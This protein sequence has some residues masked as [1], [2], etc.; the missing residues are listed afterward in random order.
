MSISSNVTRTGTASDVWIFEVSGDLS[1]A[2]GGSVPAGIKVILAGG[3][4]ASNVYWVVTGPVNGVT[5][6]TYSTFNGTILS[7]TQIVMQ[8]GAVLNGRALAQ[9]QL[10]MDHNV[11]TLPS[12]LATLHVIKS[13]VNTGGGTATTTDFTLHVK[14][15]GTD[16]VGSPALGTSTPGT[17]Y[18][19]T[20]GTYVVSENASS[21]YATSFSGDCDAS[22]NITLATGGNGV[23]TV[24]NTYTP[25]GTLHVIKLVV[26]AGPGTAVSSSFTVHVKSATSTLDVFNS[27][28]AGA[29]APGTLY[30][31]SAGTYAVSENANSL[32]TSAFTGDCD[33]SGNVVLTAGSDKIC[34]IT[35]TDIPVPAPVA[36][37]HT[38]GGGTYLPTRIVPLIG[39]TKIPTP[40][41]LPAGAGSVTYNYT[42]WNVGG[43][44]SLT[45]VSVKDDKCATVAYLS[46]DVNKNG[47]LDVGE[48]WQYSCTSTLSRTTTNTAVVTGYS[49]DGF[50]Q[51]AIGTAV[52]TV[53]VGASITP[54]LL[55]IVKVPSQLTPFPYGGGEVTYTYTVSNPGIV[56]VSDV[57]LTDD[58]C[59]TI[60][61]RSGDLNNNNLLDTNEKWIY[62]CR[63]NVPVSTR[64][65]ATVR[66]VSNGITALGYAFATVL[67]A[68]PGLPNTGYAP[69]G[70]ITIAPVTKAQA[71][72]IFHRSLSMGAKGDDVT[73]LQTALEQKGFLVM[74]SGVSKG[75]LGALTRTA[76]IKY[77]KSI[78]LPQVGTFGPLTKTKLLSELAD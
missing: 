13:I 76:I 74:P 57:R 39:I 21:T 3:A 9:T 31:L 30:T 64:N 61:G 34:T 52:S 4:K 48:N 77:Q 67:V 70:A 69:T 72:A 66:G 15:A 59:G 2:S 62:T 1:I 78:G 35:N 60:S 55:T 44:Q 36:V 33:A 40:L 12:S 23:C 8:T 18:A 73:A 14:S 5:L 11:V 24:T 38:S 68:A 26:N 6:G 28:L 27:P 41:A 45:N 43:V 20:A 54:P 58:K 65:I 51:V 75:Y 47:K 32:Y 22:G 19:L 50:N 17:S 42:V 7:A 16:V 37:N 56:P 53:V 25:P 71:N 49:D 29:A 10:T 46:G 63:V